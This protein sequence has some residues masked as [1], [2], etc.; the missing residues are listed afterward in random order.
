MMKRSTGSCSS[1]KG[2]LYAPDYVINAGGIINVAS[3]L[4]GY[5]EKQSMEKAA[6]IYDTVLTIF[7]YA[8]KHNIPTIT[9]SNILAE[10]RIK[11]VANVGTIYSSKSHFSGRKG[12]VYLRDRS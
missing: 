2:I 10:Q 4:E 9:A 11:A 7:D 5:N 3:E 1:A 8:E 6:R 12:E